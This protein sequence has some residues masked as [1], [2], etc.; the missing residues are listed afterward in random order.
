MVCLHHVM[1]LH[2][3]D[4]LLVRLYC[5]FKLLCRELHLI[6]FCSH[7]KSN[8]SQE[9]NKKSSL[10]H[11]LAEHLLH[12][13]T[14]LYNN[15]P[16]NIYCLYICVYIYIYIYPNKRTL[17]KKSSEENR[18]MPIHLDGKLQNLI[19]DK[20]MPPFRKQPFADILQSRCS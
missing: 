8:T 3:R 5:T 9:G 1:E 2:F 6:G 7:F 13:K 10:D 11:K 4:V 14:T 19:T 15:N 16:C 18:E 20:S 12:L 17:A